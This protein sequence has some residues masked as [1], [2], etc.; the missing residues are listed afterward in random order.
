MTDAGALSR[1]DARCC[2][3]D[4]D[5]EGSQHDYKEGLNSGSC[6]QKASR[7]KKGLVTGIACGLRECDLSLLR[8]SHD[9][10][11]TLSLCRGSQLGRG[12]ALLPHVIA[13]PLI[14]GEVIIEEAQTHRMKEAE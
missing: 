3:A 12:R 7:G 9:V 4:T 6:A 1:N 8:T 13:A 11:C 14:T 10:Y 5:Q 2:D